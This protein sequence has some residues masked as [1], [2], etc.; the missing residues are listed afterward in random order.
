MALD[1]LRYWMLI[2]WPQI[3]TPRGPAGRDSGPLEGK[4][5]DQGVEQW[6]RSDKQ[7]SFIHY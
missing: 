2:D 3:N 6:Q 1:H 7:D 5:M 4:S